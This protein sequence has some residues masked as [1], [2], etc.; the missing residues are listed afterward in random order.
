MDVKRYVANLA[1]YN[2][3]KLVGEWLTLSKS[4]EELEERLQV[5]MG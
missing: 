1:K 5:I 3:G 4:R 2:E